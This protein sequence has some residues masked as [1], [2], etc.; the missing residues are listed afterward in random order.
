MRVRFT[1]VPEVG[2]SRSSVRR[3]QERALDGRRA[4]SPGA[5]V[6]SLS[7]TDIPIRRAAAGPQSGVHPDVKGGFRRRLCAA[8]A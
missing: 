4:F 3:A 6:L 1:N 2:S 5:E 7:V 8:R